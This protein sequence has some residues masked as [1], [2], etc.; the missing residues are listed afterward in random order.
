[1][2]ADGAMAD[3]KPY[4]EITPY[5]G[6]G[7]LGPGETS[8]PRPLPSGRWPRTQYS[9]E[10]VVMAVIAPGTV[11]TAGLSGMAGMAPKSAIAE[12]SPR[13]SRRRCLFRVSFTTTTCLAMSA[14]TDWWFPWMLSWS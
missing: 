11:G 5:T 9:F 10:T 2:N 3:G 14:A 7:K 4:F 13:R 1:M 12:G 6:D 8:A